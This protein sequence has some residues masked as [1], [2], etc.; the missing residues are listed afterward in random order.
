MK[1]HT[2][3][4]LEKIAQVRELPTP[5]FLSKAERLERWAELLEARSHSIL[6]TLVG[7]EY[8]DEVS[9]AEMRAPNSPISI[10]FADPVLRAAGLRDDT[11]GEAKRFFEITDWDLHRTLCHCHFGRTVE[12]SEAARAVRSTLRRLQGGSWLVRLKGLFAR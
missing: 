10:A 11:Y 5:P 7:T 12:A 3:E 9:R 4:Q 6:R 2:V 8:H 1:H